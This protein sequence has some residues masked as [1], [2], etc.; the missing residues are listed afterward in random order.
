[1]TYPDGPPIGTT[2]SDD[3]PLEAKIGDELPTGSVELSHRYPTSSG[4]CQDHIDVHVNTIH[5]MPEL[6]KRNFQNKVKV[7]MLLI[8][9]DSPK[10]IRTLVH[11]DYDGIAEV[12]H[13]NEQVSDGMG[14]RR[15]GLV[16][17]GRS[18][19]DDTI[20]MYPSSW[21][22]GRQVLLV[23]SASPPP[24]GGRRATPHRGCMPRLSEWSGQIGV[25]HEILIVPW[26]QSPQKPTQFR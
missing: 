22:Q 25:W 13:C 20:L 3:T 24:S 26:V 23:A 9:T 7:S 19:P 2:P 8:S 15:S 1:M 16:I 10:S 21:A 17:T 12:D 6:Q 14:Q 4:K 5:N 18:T 11:K